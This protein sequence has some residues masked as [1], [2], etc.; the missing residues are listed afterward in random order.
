M[1]VV[2][3]TH[4]FTVS[5]WN[6]LIART[7]IKRT[8]LPERRVKE[9]YTADNVNINAPEN[10]W[11]AQWWQDFILKDKAAKL[12]TDKKAQRNVLERRCSIQHGR[13]LGL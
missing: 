5:E 1:G 6:R 9:P 13:S 2:S 12:V 11:A 4:A 8:V 3:G 10:V 7:G